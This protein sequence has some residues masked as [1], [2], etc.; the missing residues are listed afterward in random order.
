MGSVMLQIRLSVGTFMNGSIT[1]VLAS[2]ITSMS[3]LLIA[4]HPRIEDPSNPNP[5][6][7]TLS[8]SSSIGMEK[9][10]QTP[11][12]STNFKSTMSALFFFASSNASLAVIPLSFQSDPN[13]PGNKSQIKKTPQRR[14][15]PSEGRLCPPYPW[16]T[17]SPKNQ[18]LIARPERRCQAPG[19]ACARR[20]K[21]VTRTIMRLPLTLPDSPA[22]L[23]GGLE[24]GGRLVQ[25]DR[26]DRAERGEGL[27]EG[28]L[29]PDGQDDQ[30]VRMQMCAGDAG[31]VFRGDLFDVRAEALQEVGGQ[32]VILQRHLAVHDLRGAGEREDE[33]VEERLLRLLQLPLG[34]RRGHHPLQ[35]GLH[36]RDRL[37]RRARLGLRVEEERSPVE[38][39]RYH[40]A[41]HRVGQ[42]GLRADLAEEPAGERLPA[43]DVV[44]QGQGEV[45]G[46]G[47]L[48][49]QVAHADLRL[50]HVAPN[51][52]DGGRRL[53]P[54]ARMSCL[55]R[56]SRSKSPVAAIIVALGW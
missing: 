53:V 41:P 30:A 49:A 19:T 46:V 8:V 4:C 5:S 10:C 11:G 12:K 14:N 1:A 48:D 32:A 17:A 45:V 43:Q 38:V 21:A 40:R 26:A 55:T 23:R 34:H 37:R 25:G 18:P 44:Q 42:A 33:G 9:C 13:A 56:S 31:E 29:V 3:L 54:N 6:L 16:L 24:R 52:I 47:L 51:G 22:L 7:N 27:V 20:A 39:A 35:L 28:T 50:G 15:T 36:R 2:G